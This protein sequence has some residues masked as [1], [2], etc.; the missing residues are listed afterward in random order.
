MI[1]YISGGCKNGKSKIAENI[2]Y[3]LKENDKDFYYIATMKPIDEEDN[4]R[5][6]KHREDRKNMFFNTV[7]IHNNIKNLENIC[8]LN[9]TFLLDSVTALLANEMF[10]NN[11]FIKDSYK[12]VCHDLL[13]I[14]SK[15][16]N[17]VIVSDYI[18]SDSVI[19]DEIT[20]SYKKG[21]AFIDKSCAKKAD[22]LI[23]VCYNNI[24]FHKGKERFKKL[25]LC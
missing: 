24:I 22:V 15:A 13:Y 25:N 17:M 8:N 23:E 6:K 16:K 18:Y 12:K 11:T 7:E 4:K 2:A 21:L 10:Y 20:N 14:M 1:V 9:G 5:I 19:Y 3:S